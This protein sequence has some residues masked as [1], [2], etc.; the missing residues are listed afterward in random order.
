GPVMRPT[1]NTSWRSWSGGRVNSDIVGS[2]GCSHVVGAV[3]ALGVL[4]ADGAQLGAAVAGRPA[5][6]HPG[7]DGAGD[8][9]LRQQ[10]GAQLGA[11][12]RLLLDQPAGHRLQGAA[13]L[14][15]Q[16]AHLLRRPVDDAAGLDVD[17][18][19]RLLAVVA[20]LAQAAAQEAGAAAVVAED[21]AQP[22][23]AE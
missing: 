20:L 21:P 6:Q 23:H 10:Q 16:L 11:L 13:V 15:H 22:A 7:V 14:P 4:V 17:L 5:L 8:G 9:A 2:R 3:A 1:W 12:H 18:A 19:G